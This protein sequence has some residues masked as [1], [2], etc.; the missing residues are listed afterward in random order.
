MA[1]NS[2]LKLKCPLE[3]DHCSCYEEGYKKSLMETQ[4]DYRG[5][6]MLMRD[7][8]AALYVYH[9]A[10]L[11]VHSLYSKLELL[12]HYT[13]EAELKSKKEKLESE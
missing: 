1:V 9:D 12:N 10:E 3:E 4:R 5:M 7:Q 11:D 6:L 13:R 2:E 8:I